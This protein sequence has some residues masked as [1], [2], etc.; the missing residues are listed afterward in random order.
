MQ[1]PLPYVTATNTS[2]GPPHVHGMSAGDYLAARHAAIEAALAEWNEAKAAHDAAGKR[3]AKLR[4]REPAICRALKMTPAELQVQRRWA[5]TGTRPQAD[6]HDVYVNGRK[7]ANWTCFRRSTLA[8]DWHERLA[9]AEADEPAARALLAGATRALVAL[10][11]ARDAATLTGL[12]PAQL[13]A[14]SRPAS[15]R[16]ASTPHI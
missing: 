7:W 12:T 13:S 1:L 14:L 6:S 15:R 8:Q 11:G 3:L 10:A 4:A 5:R 16:A 2:A 9:Q